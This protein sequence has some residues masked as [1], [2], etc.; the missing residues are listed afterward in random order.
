MCEPTMT[1]LWNR[2]W[3]S[4]KGAA[5]AFIDDYAP[6]MGA[7][8]A[9]YTMFSIAPLLFIVIMLAGLI[10]GEE[11]A[12]GEIFA[13]LRGLMG[14]QGASA[15]QTMV[16]SVKE[17]ATGAIGTVIGAIALLIGATT[18]FGELQSALDRVWR[19][20]P[21]AKSSGLWA[22]VRT[23]LLSFGMILGVG[24]LLI[25]SLIASAALAALGKWWGP[26]LGSWETLAQVLN[27]AI[28]FGL[29]TAAFAL[30]YK[31]MPRARIEWHDVW[32]GAAVTALLFTMGKFLIGL[33]IGKSAI[34]SGFGAAGSIVVVIVWVYYSAQIFL[35]GAEFTWVYAHEFGSRQGERQPAPAGE[36]PQRSS[37][38]APAS[39][40]M[41]AARAAR[42]S[43]R[44]RHARRPGAAFDAPLAFGIGC[45]LTAIFARLRL[46]P[47]DESARRLHWSG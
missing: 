24:F 25:V 26:L 33:Y 1:P 27:V 44:P 19:S 38:L 6:S 14:E 12:S 43:R 5:A 9:Y 35:F 21:R 2:F 11:A 10:F 18:V 42:A 46:K 7:A 31:F 23:R 36:V 22:M 3:T 47:E 32:I 29:F 28:S 16:Q 15:I 34:A 37:G 39:G 17:P 41:P 30:I 4:I 8:L 20:P 13:Q 45:L 40:P